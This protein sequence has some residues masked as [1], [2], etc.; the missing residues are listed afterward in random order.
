MPIF[1]FYKPRRK[2]VEKA[3]NVDFVITRLLNAPCD[4]DGALGLSASN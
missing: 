3:A 4:R 1:K 2:T